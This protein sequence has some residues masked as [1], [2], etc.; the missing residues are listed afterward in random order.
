[1][2]SF[3][4]G[5]AVTLIL[6][7]L[8]PQGAFAAGAEITK[9]ARARGMAAAPGLVAA[10]HLDCQVADARMIGEGTDPKTKI[11]ESLYELACAGNEG[12]VLQQSGS[13]APASFT[14]LQMAELGADGKKSNAACTLPGNADPKAGLAA[15]TA[16]V[17]IPCTLDKA[18]AIGQS[19]TNAVFEVACHETP[20][21]FI[22]MTSA[23]PRLDQ[24]VTMN[25]CFGYPEDSNLACKLTDRAAQSAAVDA[26]VTQSGKTCAIKDRRFIGATDS[27]KIYYEVACQDGKGYVLE[28]AANGAFSKAIDCVQADSIA[29]GCTLT[30]TRQAKTEQDSLY[31]KLAKAAGFNC[32]VSGYAPLPVSEDGKEVV[33][34]TCSN[35][36]DGGIGLFAA[37]ASQ[38]SDVFDCAHSELKGFRC[39]L[40]KADAAYP[41][42]TAELKTLGKSTC[43]VSNARAV[44][45]TSSGEGY[46]EV[47]CSDG[48]PG[49]M[50]EFAMSPFAPKAPIP[51]SEAHGINGGCTL[52]GNKK[53]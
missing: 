29:G 5:L 26:L 14:C 3:G 2:R 46:I 6:S 32:D 20:G 43:T 4:I 27:H 24:P 33:E 25:P 1:M 12:M 52:A 10:A 50:I 37:T 38:K 51:C 7:A 28:Q 48:L 15:Y 42:L 49:Y 39:S 53:G 8:A 9:E 19:P 36:P 22:L 47:A 21:G 40:T 30:D 44:G 23:P 11:K 17:G 35:R 45:V 41:H 18:R 13:N 16:K 31:S 34:L